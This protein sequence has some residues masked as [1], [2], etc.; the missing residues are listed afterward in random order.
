MKN[1]IDLHMHS[2]FSD[3]G[4]FTPAE[5]VRQCK[6]AGIRVMSLTDHDSARG[7]TEAKKEAEKYNIKY[8]TGIEIDCTFQGINL[9][10]LGYGINAESRDFKELEE[11]ILSGERNASRDRLHLTRQLGFD[12][13]EAEL[14]AISNI[15]DGTGIW[16]GE[17]FAEVLLEKEAYRS[18]E[19][20]LPYREDGERGDNPFVNFYWDYYAQ[21]KPCY[22]K[23]DFPELKEAID[24]IQRN[25]GK[26]VLAH[27]GNNLK[28][29]FELFA[30]IVKLG[31]DGVEVFCSYHDEEIAKYFYE[32]AVKHSLIMTLGSDYHG[33]TK[34]S[35]KLGDTGCWLNPQE[36]MEQLDLF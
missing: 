23:V 27:P 32:Q 25:N 19:L 5:I 6:E 29:R 9:H 31:I 11:S 35:V 8:I 3:D 24:I 14:N 15:D 22:V 18:H 13:S 4:E 33:K 16:T 34:P 30:E 36:I 26:A 1:Y 10:L 17:V 7:N 20:L 28:G 2:T 12:I 21:G